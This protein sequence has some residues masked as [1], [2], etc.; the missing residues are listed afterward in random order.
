MMEE[1]EIIKMLSELK[2]R[3]FPRP[4]ER[5]G[6]KG[7]NLIGAEI[8]IYKGIHVESLLENLSIKKLYLIDPYELYDGFEE[9]KRH[10]G[11]DQDPLEIVEEEA[12]RRL[13]NYSDR[14][15]WVKKKSGEAL[16][17]IPDKLD[18]VY[19]DGNHQYEFV[20]QNIES[21]FPKIKEGGII[22]GHDI[23]NGYSYEHNGVVQAV[24]EFAFE[25]H[26]QLYIELPDWWVIK[27]GYFKK[28]MI[29]GAN[30]RK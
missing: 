14:I 1:K 5:L 11:I 24:I 29:Y 13:K 19:D 21:Y 4:F 7:E 27:G 23:S 18:F 20:K 17:N 16:E 28:E 2:H 30:Q 6:V 22:G 15:V 25:H 9:G 12:R 3:I 26:L 10:Y 8:G